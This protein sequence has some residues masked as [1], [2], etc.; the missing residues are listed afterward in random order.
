MAK[1]KKYESFDEY[2]NHQ[3][4][5]NQAIIGALRPFVKRIKPKLKESVKWGNGC[6]IGNNGP[7]AYWKYAPELSVLNAN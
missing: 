7:V 2:S 3:S 4:P 6:W 5:K 1:R